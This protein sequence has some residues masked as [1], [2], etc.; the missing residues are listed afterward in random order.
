MPHGLLLHVL[1]LL[2]LEGALK[3]VGVLLDLPFVHLLL[4]PD[5][6]V[7]LFVLLRALDAEVLLPLI[8]VQLIVMDLDSLCLVLVLITLWDG[9]NL[10]LRDGIFLSLNH[11]LQGLNTRVG[12][13]HGGCVVVTTCTDTTH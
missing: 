12:Q 1:H 4:P 11:F 8:L 7:S 5:V 2:L 3:L 13:L 9:P 10:S 6:V